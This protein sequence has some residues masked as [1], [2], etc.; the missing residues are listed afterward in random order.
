MTTFKANRR[1]PNPITVNDDPRSHTL[2][3]QQLIEAL[4]IGQRRTR[5]IGSSYVRVQELVDVGLIEIVGNQLKLTNL[6]QTVA[7][8]GATT[9]DGLTDVDT[10][11]PSDGDVLTFDT[12]TGLWLPVAPTVTDP[13]DPTDMY[14]AALNDLADV[15][16]GPPSNGQALVYNSSTGKWEATTLSIPDPFD[17]TDMYAA[18][19]NDLADVSFGPPTDG[20]VLRYNAS[21][22][23]W[24]AASITAAANSTYG[25]YCTGADAR[26]SNTTL[27]DDTVLQIPMSAGKKYILKF[28]LGFSTN[29]T[30]DMKW[31]LNYTGTVGSIST[32]I[33]Y[34]TYAAAGAGN[35]TSGG[36]SWNSAINSLVAYNFIGNAHMVLRIEVSVQVTTTGTFTFRWAQGTS[37]IGNT[38]RLANSNVLVTEVS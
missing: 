14:A 37:N 9:L 4:N 20:Y 13:F 33:S 8:G 24:E 25:I 1:F 34:N 17:P 35:G 7:A 18:A 31:D 23:K 38:T 28:V 2:A 6:G 21:T 36:E 26:A 32:V 10:P 5:E 27:T 15:S 29:T 22:G 16:F 19:L 11:A 12:G 3:L 30:A